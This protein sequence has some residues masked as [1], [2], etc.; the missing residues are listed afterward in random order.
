[1]HFV[2]LGHGE[3]VVWL[4]G[5]GCDGS[6]FLPAARLVDMRSLLVDMH[7]FGKSPP[8]PE[9]GWSVADY[10]E[11]VRDFFCER[12]IAGAVIVGHSFGCRVALVLAAKYP[13][14]VRR[15]VL[16]APAGMRRFSLK[17]WWQV[18][19]YKLSRGKSSRASADYLACP[20]AMR[21]TL[22]KVVNED[23]ARYAR[24]VSCPVLIV[25]GRSDSAVP[26]WQV[27]RL[28][29]L[30]PSS[31]LVEIEGDHFALLRSPTALARVVSDFVE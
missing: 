17:R 4:H 12:Q 9:E 20:P 7:G 25:G 22:V 6:V 16:V 31:S 19:R 23:L 27:R 14:L 8:P 15:M 26:P 5:W 24:R 30:I 18:A 1:M 11:E 21:R 29:R 13:Q 2:E 10:A 28:H 3:P